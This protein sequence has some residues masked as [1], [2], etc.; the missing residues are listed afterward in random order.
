MSVHHQVGAVNQRIF[1]TRPDLPPQLCRNVQF[2]TQISEAHAGHVVQL[3]A[4]T[5]EESQPH[6][7]LLGDLISKVSL[8]KEFQ[9]F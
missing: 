4:W 1:K 8:I 9:P 3:R 7:T 2:G 5:G 6:R